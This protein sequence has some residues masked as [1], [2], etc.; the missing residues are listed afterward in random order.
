MI[1]KFKDLENKIKY[2]FI[3]KDILKRELN[4]QTK[5]QKD[6]DTL[7]PPLKPPP[8]LRGGV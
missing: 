3:S 7:D 4:F 8:F 2:K 5:N 6:I 1:N